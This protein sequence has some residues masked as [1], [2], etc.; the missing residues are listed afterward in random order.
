[1]GCAQRTGWHRICLDIARDVDSFGDYFYLSRTSQYLDVYQV[2][3]KDTDGDGQLEPDQHPDNPLH[4]GPM[5]ERALT[6]VL[7]TCR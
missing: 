1:M 7:T 5:E 6:F 4:T 2:T 3:L